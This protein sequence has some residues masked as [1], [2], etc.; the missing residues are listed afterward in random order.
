L[1]EKLDI[2]AARLID[3]GEDWNRQLLSRKAGNTELE[4]KVGWKTKGGKNPV[5]VISA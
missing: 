3:I 4:K 5:T 2:F 1:L